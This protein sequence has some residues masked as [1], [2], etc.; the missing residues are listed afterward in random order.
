MK[1]E[2]HIPNVNKKGEIEEKPIDDI[3]SKEE[4]FEDSNNIRKN[5][6]I[7]YN[8]NDFNYLPYN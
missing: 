5:E 2:E 4:N 8:S 3:D 1:E 7:N 6:Y